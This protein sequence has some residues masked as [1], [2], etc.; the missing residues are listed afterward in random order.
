MRYSPLTAETPVG[1]ARLYRQVRYT[2]RKKRPGRGDL[3]FHSR[4]M[5]CCGRGVDGDE[6]GGVEAR[7]RNDV[8]GERRARR[9][10][11]IVD[12]GVR[13]AEVALGSRDVGTMTVG[14]SRTTRRLAGR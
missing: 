1:C 12:D 13:L 6:R 4:E 7:L 2:S 3:C 9:S 10:Q 5:S 11:S 14:I 8:V